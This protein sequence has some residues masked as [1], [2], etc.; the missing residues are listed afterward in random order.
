MESNDKSPTHPM[1]VKMQERREPNS[2]EDKK[3]KNF[4]HDI[5]E[6]HSESTHTSTNPNSSHTGSTNIIVSDLSLQ[7][8]TREGDAANAGEGFDEYMDALNPETAAEP[9]HVARPPRF[10]IDDVDDEIPYKDFYS[11]DSDKENDAT[12]TNVTRDIEKI[13]AGERHWHR[14]GSK[15]AAHAEKRTTREDKG[16]QEWAGSRDEVFASAHSDNNPDDIPALVSDDAH[17][18]PE[19]EADMER[20]RQESLLLSYA[21]LRS[22]SSNKTSSWQPS[23]KAS[24]HNS[25]NGHP[26]VQQSILN[27]LRTIQPNDTNT[28]NS[29]SGEDVAGYAESDIDGNDERQDNG[30]KESVDHDPW[31][32]IGMARDTF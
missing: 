5:Q 13:E 8:H 27:S 6:D 19:F 9:E 21:K 11:A 18:D 22:T 24:S 31:T 3:N 25:G 17:S 1:N 20:A 29:K 32:A 26:D 4:D 28:T 10:P 14:N 7:V 30:S 15:L 2:A 23:V 16:W 12:V